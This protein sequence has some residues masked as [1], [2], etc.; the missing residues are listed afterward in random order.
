MRFRV[1]QPAPGTRRS[2]IVPLLAT[3]AA[4]IQLTVFNALFSNTIGYNNTATGYQA[5]YSN[6]DAGNNTAAGYNALY[7]N[8]TGTNNTATGESAL[9]N[10]T[11]GSKNIA[12]GDHA[13]ARLTAGSHNIDI[14]NVGVPGESNTIRIGTGENSSA[15]F[16]AGISGTTVATGVGVIINSNGRL[17][18]IT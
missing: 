17:G 7:N 9:L 3:P 18:T 12:L 1:T 6:T 10:N 13:G 2:V 11:T 8:T 5:L 14:G 15:T 4:T 16:V